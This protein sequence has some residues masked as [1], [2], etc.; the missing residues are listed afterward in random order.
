MNDFC[1]FQKDMKLSDVFKR[2]SINNDSDSIYIENMIKVIVSMINNNDFEYDNNKFD[3][4]KC[5]IYDF[6]SLQNMINVIKVFLYESTNIRILQNCLVH[7]VEKF[8][9]DERFFNENIVNIQ[10]SYVK[11]FVLQNKCYI[12]VHY[13][14]RICVFY[15]D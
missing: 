5:I 15:R 14:L 11:N 1:D 12:D 4:K 8:I 13:L 10:K 3:L 2:G 6:N 7:I 9:F